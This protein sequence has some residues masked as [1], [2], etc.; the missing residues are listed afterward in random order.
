LARQGA[1]RQVIGHRR[2]LTVVQAVSIFVLKGWILEARAFTGEEGGKRMTF[3]V[4]ANTYRILG[5]GRSAAAGEGA[6]NDLGE[7]R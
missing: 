5:S 7:Y 4:V 1:R 2:L 3:R 6:D